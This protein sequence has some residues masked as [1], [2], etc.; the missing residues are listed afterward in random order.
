[1]KKLF[2]RTGIDALVV[3]KTE[4]SPE[5]GI[6]KGRK[7]RLQLPISLPLPFFKVQ[8]DGRGRAK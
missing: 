2:S 7:R 8:A 3:G 1:M 5:G 4:S 6:K